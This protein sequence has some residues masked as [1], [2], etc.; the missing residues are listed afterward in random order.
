[1]HTSNITSTKYISCDGASSHFSNYDKADIKY[2]LCPQRIWYIWNG[3]NN[4]FH[5]Q[6]QFPFENNYSFLSSSVPS[7]DYITNPNWLENIVEPN[8]L[9][10]N[11]IDLERKN[12]AT[13]V[14][15]KQD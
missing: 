9:S 10:N 3:C 14:F 6:K 8:K 11:I 15:P 4:T 5:E 7:R 2:F 12:S 1:M 13:S